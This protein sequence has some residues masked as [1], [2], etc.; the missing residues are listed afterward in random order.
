MCNLF[1]DM[2]DLWVKRRLG[3]NKQDFAY[4]PGNYWIIHTKK[5]QPI[6][7][8]K[9]LHEYQL[10]GL[11]VQADNVLKEIRKENKVALRKLRL[12]T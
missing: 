3:G 1:Q 11:G 12:K 6:K 7:Y 8:F 10:I 9:N 4:E 5:Q 2:Y